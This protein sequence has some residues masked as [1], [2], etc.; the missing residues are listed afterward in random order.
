MI[1]KQ[2]Q[3]INKFKKLSLKHHQLSLLF[4]ELA[5]SLKIKAREFGRGN[6]KAFKDYLKS[7]NIDVDKL[8]EMTKGDMDIITLKKEVKE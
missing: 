7:I 8:N 1:T 6:V 2:Q 4:N 3:I 5:G